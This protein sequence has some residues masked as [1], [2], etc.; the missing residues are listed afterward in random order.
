VGP[1]QRLWDPIGGCGR[2]ALVFSALSLA[3]ERGLEVAKRAC[4]FGAGGGGGGLTWLF[5]F[6][7]LAVWFICCFS[8]L[9]RRP[10][11]R[12]VAAAVAALPFLLSCASDLPRCLMPQSPVHMASPLARGQFQGAVWRRRLAAPFDLRE[13]GRQSGLDRKGSPLFR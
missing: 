9:A 8:G 6:A 12:C 1:R 7:P 2:C 5:A 10:C 3:S 11:S 4:V 13:P